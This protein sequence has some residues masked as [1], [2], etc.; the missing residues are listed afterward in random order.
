M[1]RAAFISAAALGVAVVAAKVF[2]RRRAAKRARAALKSCRFRSWPITET[3]A[4]EP[5]LRAMG[6]KVAASQIDGTGTGKGGC[7][8][9]A[10]VS[11][12]PAG[13]GGTGSFVSADGLI[14]TNHHVAHDAVRRASTP[15]N[16]LLRDGF[17]ARSRADE[18]RAPGYEVWITTACD[19]VSAEVLA[20]VDG[21]SEPLARANAVR[22]VKEAIA[23]AREAAAA[24]AEPSAAAGLRC[25]V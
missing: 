15:D 17:V 7:L 25:K 2:L 6:L 13:H 11:V 12:G 9:D 5:S 8:S 20:A 21:I 3:T 14:I 19:D 1:G 10:L 4:L 24:A 22:D 16:D 18:V 23:R